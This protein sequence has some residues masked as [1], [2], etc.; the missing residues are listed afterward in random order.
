MQMSSQLELATLRHEKN[1]YKNEISET[2][3]HA[4]EGVKYN[5]RCID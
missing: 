4:P 1:R 3:E 5:V 2:N